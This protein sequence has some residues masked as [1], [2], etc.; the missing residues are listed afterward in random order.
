M[1]ENRIKKH[2][3]L[4]TEEKERVNFFWNNQSLS[5]IKSEPLSS[6]LIANGIHVF[7]HHPKDNSPQG[8]FCANGQCSQCMVIAD[9]LPVKACI[10][11]LRSGMNIM[12]ADQIISLP[13]GKKT[14]NFNSIKNIKI[15]VLIIGG[16]PAGLSAAL[17]LA[18][19][20]IRLILIDDKQL[21]GGK[22]ILQT[23]RF[24]GSTK[25]VYA[26]TRG[27]EI[28]NK[29]S[30][31]IAIN[32]SIEIWTNST[33][34]AVFSDQRVGI[35]KNGDKYVM[36]EPDH[37][38]ISCGAREK[39]LSFKGNTLP[40]VFGAGAFQTLVNRD[41]VLPG[42]RIFIVG[43]GNVGLIAGYHALQAGIEVA[44]L[45]EAMPECGG[46][47]V[48][49]DKL[50]RLGIPIFTSHTI[51]SANGKEHVESIT[52]VQVNEKFQIIKGTE[53]I[54]SCDCILI[55][56]GLDPVN[57]FFRKAIE[58]KM[59]VFAAGDAEEIA[60]A[61]SAIISGKVKGFEITN[62][63]NKLDSPI[64]QSWHDLKLILASKPGKTRIERSTG[65]KQGVFPVFHCTQEIPCDPCAYLCSLGLI[66]IIGLDIRKLPKFK[67]INKNCSGCANCV[68]GCPGLA[69]TLVDYRK[70]IETPIVSIPF[71]FNQG[72]IK[73][74][75]L[76][77]VLNTKGETL[78]KV[79]VFE[80][81]ER[82]N[83]NGTRLIK[84]S[85]PMKIAEEIA[86]IKIQ[87][88]LSIQEIYTPANLADEQAIVCRCERV[89]LG[90]IRKLIRAGY[91]D[92][93]EIK[94]ITRAGMGSCGGKTC[95]SL[96]SQV[97]KE[98]NISMNEITAQTIRPLFIEI[99][100]N[101]LAGLTDHNK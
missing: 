57:E 26:G 33:A 52:I 81:I 63:I 3:I 31:E 41:L 40:G 51:L 73:V 76:V 91:R 83:F 70:N 74:G 10:T 97:F 88:S 66:N 25:T 99:P 28:A 101:I 1:V 55:A 53:R 38:L 95:Q 7:G 80:I 37:L 39:F 32:P 13:P 59:S 12:P 78:A 42:K 23:H 29:L 89:A 49:K 43:G 16:G 27:I 54:I 98:E 9:G 85:S 50:N 36:V 48:H 87:D 56:V 17:E 19:S 62:K 61:S 46:Y 44:G 14:G 92:I 58:F 86:G 93:N 24:F 34:I 8:I 45:I 96:I 4:T 6:A 84:V 72:T 100:L 69:I 82:K 47:K 18:K 77:T 67:E 30:N 64:P 22:L 68:A 20:G 35:L 65:R 79:P 94:T 71:E 2:P 11:P 5:G 75:D 15:P 60:E 90:E 21:L